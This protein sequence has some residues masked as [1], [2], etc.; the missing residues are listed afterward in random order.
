MQ[1]DLES[2]EQQESARFLR[3]YEAQAS[4]SSH[5]MYAIREPFNYS[6]SY[7][8]GSVPYSFQVRQEPYVEMYIPQERYKQLVENERLIRRLEDDARHYKGIVEMYRNDERVRD[9]NPVVKKAWQKY[10]TL[11]ELMRK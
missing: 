11:L 3:K 8:L 9:N 4:L 2:T 1:K 7:D 6:A 10:L 5:R